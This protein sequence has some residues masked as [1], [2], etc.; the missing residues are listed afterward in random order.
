MIFRM[1]RSPIAQSPVTQSAIERIAMISRRDAIQKI[2]TVAG[3]A[4][5]VP[6]SVNADSP[7]PQQAPTQPSRSTPPSVVSNPPRDFTPGAQPVTYPDPDIITID[8]SFNS[9][10]L[11]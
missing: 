7:R 2:G 4:A 10:R 3:V 8:P 11:G 9:L 1:T 6:R 5:F